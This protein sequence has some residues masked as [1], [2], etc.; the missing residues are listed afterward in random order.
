MPQIFL[1][2]RLLSSEKEFTAH[3]KAN[4]KKESESLKDHHLYRLRDGLLLGSIDIGNHSTD[5]ALSIYLS[6]DEQ[7]NPFAG[8]CKSINLLHTGIKIGE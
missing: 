5:K 8:M 3:W 4:F 6:D 1:E 2:F 7:T